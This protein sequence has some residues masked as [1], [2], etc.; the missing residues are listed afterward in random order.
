MLGTSPDLKGGIAAVVRTLRE[1][2]LFDRARIEY[3]VTHLDTGAFGKVLQFSRAVVATLR[4]LLKG[5]VALVHVHVS[6]NASFWRKATLLWIARRFGVPTVFHL[7][8]GGFDEFAARG[9]PIRR[10]CI[11]RSL[12]A[13]SVVVVLSKHWHDWVEQFA[14]GSKVRVVANPVQVPASIHDRSKAGA[15]AHAGRV[16]FLGKICDEKGTFDLLHAWQ[17]FRQVAPGWRLAI[18]GFGE[19]ERFLEEASRIG[20]RDDIEYLGWVA[21][22]AK[23]RELASADIF[24]LPSY[25]EGMPVAILEAMAFGAAVIATPVGGVPDMMEAGVHGVWVRQGDVV[26]LAD[27][28]VRLA[29]SPQLRATL[30]AASRKHV[31]SHYATEKVVEQIVSLYREVAANQSGRARW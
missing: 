7:H 5:D 25:K 19:V 8:S 10:W 3:V 30:A 13:S 14:P 9:G 1:S 27:A 28:I 11:R 12:R 26:G 4:A 20:V 24:V 2:G 16:L 18:G 15:R 17:R 21:G 22:E 31:A 6:F 29:G 23:A